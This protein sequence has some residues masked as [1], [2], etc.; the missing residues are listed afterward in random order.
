MTLFAWRDPKDGKHEH[1][2]AGVS[3]EWP[4]PTGDR[5]EVP[6]MATPTLRVK[7]DR[8]WLA[9]RPETNRLRRQGDVKP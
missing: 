9:P 4:L 7:P 8:R 6:A 5:S 1:D 3:S 2:V